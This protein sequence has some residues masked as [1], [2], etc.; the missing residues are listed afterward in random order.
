MHSPNKR[1]IKQLNNTNQTVMLTSIAVLLAS[2]ISTA[3]LPTLLIR[4]MYA[5]QQLFEQPALLEYIPVVSF[6]I[7]M[8]YFVYAVVSNLMRSMHIANLEKQMELDSMSCGD[9]C[10]G[11]CGPEGHH[12]H[13]HHSMGDVDSLAE[14]LMKKDTAAKKAVKKSKTTSKK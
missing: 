1:K 12:G 13:D 6:V 7:G 8:G 11:D 3:I 10:C 4:Y 2:L 14:A 9:D 5:G